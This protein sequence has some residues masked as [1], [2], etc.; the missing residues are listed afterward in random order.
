MSHLGI[1]DGLTFIENLLAVIGVPNFKLIL[2][3]LDI[4]GK[5]Y[6]LVLAF[7]V[8]SDLRLYSQ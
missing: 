5:R 7:K 1:D 2:P 3:G 4:E 6:N 8:L